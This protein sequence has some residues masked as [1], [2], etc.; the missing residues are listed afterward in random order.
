MKCLLNIKS[1]Q[2]AVVSSPEPKAISIKG[3]YSVVRR[4]VS[5]IIFF[6]ETAGQIYFKFGL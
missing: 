6:S 1:G 4:H 5:T 3:G 2:I